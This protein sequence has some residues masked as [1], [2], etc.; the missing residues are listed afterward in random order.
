LGNFREHGVLL[1]LSKDL[2]SGWVRLQADKDL[3]R[4]YAGLLPFTEGLYRLGYISKE[5]YEEHLKKY[6][7]PLT[8]KEELTDSQLK[9]K[10]RLEK[11]NHYFKAVLEEW[12]NRPIEWK[13]KM[14][15]YAKKHSE[16]ENAKLLIAKGNAGAG[17]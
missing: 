7:Q 9:E 6:S 5:V 14:I 10:E 4:T 15:S 2:Y 1:Y 12:D 13:N 3:G 16:S 8:A 11:E 17:S